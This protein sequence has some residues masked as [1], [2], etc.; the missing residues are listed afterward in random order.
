M[1]NFITLGSTPC[2][3]PCACVGQENY[4]ERALQECQRYIKLLR[5]VLGSEPYGA[6]LSTK[7]FEHDFGHYVEVICYYD[8]DIPESVDYAY[9]CEDEMPA[10][11]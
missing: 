4:R 8:T 1:R 11:W 10:T 9:R 2:D 3:E 5:A 7:W 6:R